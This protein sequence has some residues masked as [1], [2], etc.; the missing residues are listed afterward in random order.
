MLHLRAGYFMENLLPQIGLIQ[1]LGMMGGSLRA[2]LP[3]ALIATRDIGAAAAE[4]LLKLAFSGKQTR[5]LLSQR[6]V[7]MTE[8]ATV[9]GKAIGKPNLAYL[10]FPAAQVEQALVQM[11]T[12]RGAAKLLL[13]MTD[14]LNSGYMAPLEPRSAENTTPTSIETFVAEEFVPRFQGKA[15]RA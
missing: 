11:G 5:E 13:E 7:T 12:S 8:A 2:D 15:A 6:D 1:T 4:A 10:Q 9:T 14:S 3:L